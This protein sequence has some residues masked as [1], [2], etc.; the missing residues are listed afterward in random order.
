MI[1]G[2]NSLS[3]IDIDSILVLATQRLSKT[4][5]SALLDAEVL[6]CYVLG[7]TRSYLRAWPE[8]ELVL[9][10]QK[11]FEQL[12][13]Q[14]EQGVPIAYITGYREFWSRNFKVTPDV[15]IP[16]PDTELLVELSLSLIEN[17]SG[18]RIIDLGTGSGAIA[19]TLAAE[20]LDID[21]TA[22]D[23]S[24][25]A[26]AVARQNALTHQ[27]DNIRFIHSNWFAEVPSDNKFDLI[28]SNP[29]Y[30]APQ[31]PHLSQGDLRFEPKKALVASN[32]G[33]EDIRNIC[34]YAKKYLANQGML[35]IEHGFDQKVEVQEIFA[36]FSYDNINTHKDLSGNPRV[37][38][39]EI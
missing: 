10:E 36:L 37:T 29:P 18:V 13:M 25:Q 33:L 14:R 17:K 22:I 19:I 20:R 1:E 35:L 2:R 24:E 32:Q 27:A 39:G 11:H 9:E 4:S 38:I 6:L 26:L 34:R 21:V 28:I 7:K 15:L 12:L 23:D 5:D 31:D 3:K 8:K 30:I 16:R